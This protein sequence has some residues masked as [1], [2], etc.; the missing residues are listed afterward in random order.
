MGF[1]RGFFFLLPVQQRARHYYEEQAS[2]LPIYP[3]CHL[4]SQQLSFTDGRQVHRNA[5][6]PFFYHRTGVGRT[7]F[8][9]TYNAPESA[10][11]QSFCWKNFI[12]AI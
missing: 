12:G 7:G 2:C 3:F 5:A 10:K 11:M 1:C 8:A 4:F 9:F 6:S